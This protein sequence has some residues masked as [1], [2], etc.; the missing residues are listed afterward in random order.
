VKVYSSYSGVVNA[1]PVPATPIISAANVNYNSVK[2]SWAAIG[3]ATGY[4]VSYAK[5]IDGT[6]TVLPLQAAAS[7]TLTGQ[8]TNSPVY[9]KVRAYRLVGTVKVFGLASS[10]ASAT[11]YPA[12]PVISAVPNI[13]KVTLTWLA[14]PGITKYSIYH[15]EDGA[16]DFTLLGESTGLTYI[17]E[18]LI[19]NSIH[20]YK[21]VGSLMVD[22]T[23]LLTSD[24]NTLLITV[25]APAVSGLTAVSTAFDTIN[26]RWN[27][28]VGATGY[29]VSMAT[30]STG[31]Y[32]PLLETDQ[33]SFV[34]TG[35]SFNTAYYFKVRPFT[36]DGATNVYGLSAPIVSAKTTLG[37]PL[38]T[39]KS[40]SATSINLTWLAIPGASGY[41]VYR[42]T[43]LT[44]TAVLQSTITTLSYT[45]TALIKGTVYY[46]KARAYRLVGTV[47]VY[48]AFSIIKYVRVGY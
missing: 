37:T 46:Y 7:Y 41:E 15:K 14:I 18:S 26:L 11:P 10:I 6:Y 16:V 17:H 5:I 45:K 22:T 25:A 29:E 4:E 23:E 1:R 34:K 36:L 20:T 32:T 9:F 39:S 31:V 35:L 21:V 40:L 44:G 33:L 13:D 24:S 28:S 2:A 12:A 47:K 48:G 19:L 3:G 8:V 30:S 27:A 38:V 42:S 43:T